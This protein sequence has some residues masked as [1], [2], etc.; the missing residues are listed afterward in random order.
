MIAPMFSH[1]VIFWTDPAQ[2]DAAD[3]V[4]AGANKYLKGI[5]GLTHFHIGKMVGSARPVVDQTYQVA[6]NAVFTSKQAED[7][8]QIHPEHLKFVAEFVKPY[9]KKVTVYDFE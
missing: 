6:L 2:A 3:Q 1:I 8:Y 7:A 9:V 4:I 5:P